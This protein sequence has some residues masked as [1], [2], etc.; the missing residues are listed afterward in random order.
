[1]TFPTKTIRPRAFTLRYPDNFLNMGGIG[2]IAEPLVVIF[3]LFGGTWINRDFKPGRLRRRPTAARS[4]SADS[5][6][7]SWSTHQHI[8]SRSTSPSLLVPQE[9]EWRTRTLAAFG[10]T[11]EVATPNTRRFKAYFLSRI[12]ERFPFLVECWYWAL[13][14][15]VGETLPRL[16]KPH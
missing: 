4:V 5:Y 3:L 9:P 10:L 12:L 6:V 11:K 14:Y 16:N 15:W 2:A 13:I 8:E 7:V 1:M